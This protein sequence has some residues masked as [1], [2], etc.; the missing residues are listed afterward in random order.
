MAAQYLVVQ[1]PGAY[2]EALGFI[3]VGMSFYAP[4]EQFVPARSMR[5]MNQ[6]A[7]AGMTKLKEALL[8]EAKRCSEQA[9]QADTSRLRREALGERSRSLEMAADEV[10]A[11]VISIPKL[12]KAP[13]KLSLSQMGEIVPLVQPQKR[14]GS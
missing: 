1:A 10:E 14:K 3:P 7:S 8:S 9:K 13:E 6:E 11:S 12:E 5:A 2:I 4:G